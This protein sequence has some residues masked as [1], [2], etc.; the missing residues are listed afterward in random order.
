MIWRQEAGLNEL[1]ESHQGLSTDSFSLSS[2]SLSPSS[3][4]GGY[5]RTYVDAHPQSSHWQ[6]SLR[7]EKALLQVGNG[8][9][10]DRY[11]VM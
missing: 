10:S 5:Q 4:G 2:S 11:I 7:R 9:C 6:V 8:I 1:N 3:S